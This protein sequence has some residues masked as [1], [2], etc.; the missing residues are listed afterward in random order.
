MKSLSSGVEV[1]LVLLVA[2]AVLV[3]GIGLRQW[4]SPWE[5]SLLCPKRPLGHQKR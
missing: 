4:P 1:R 5:T 2:S 3:S